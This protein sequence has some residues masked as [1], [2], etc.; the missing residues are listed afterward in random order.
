MYLTSIAY[1]LITSKYAKQQIHVYVTWSYGF[2]N[3]CLGWDTL[4]VSVNSAGL[5]IVAIVQHG[6]RQ[7][8]EV[9]RPRR[10]M[11][12]THYQLLLKWMLF[13]NVSANRSL[14]EDVLITAFNMVLEK[15]SVS[16]SID[17]LHPFSQQLILGNLCR[18]TRSG[19]F[20]NL[21]F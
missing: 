14:Y 2:L 18:A 11:M 15:A 6:H 17:E 1:S 16:R 9:T 20:I 12:V 3:L 8:I 10:S 13:A 21:S 19:H 4:T 7:N 5:G